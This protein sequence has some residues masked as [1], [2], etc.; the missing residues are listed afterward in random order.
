MPESLRSPRATRPARRYEDTAGVEVDIATSVAFKQVAER[1]AA[2]RFVVLIDCHTFS[3]DRG[4]A[5]RRVAALVGAFVRKLLPSKL[6]F[7]FIFTKTDALLG[8]ADS[9]AVV[10]AKL[11]QVLIETLQGTTDGDQ[12]EFINWLITCIHFDNSLVDVY[13]PAFSK[14]DKL[15]SAIETFEKPSDG[16]KPPATMA[17]RSPRTDVRCGLTPKAES[18]IKLDLD[19]QLDELDVALANGCIASAG[20]IVSTLSFL[21]EQVD[22]PYVHAAHEKALKAWGER[23]ARVALGRTY[24]LIDCGFGR[25]EEHAFDEEQGREALRSLGT[26]RLFERHPAPNVQAGAAEKALVHLRRGLSEERKM[27]EAGLCS[28]DLTAAGVDQGHCLSQEL[29]AFKH[30]M[31]SHSRLAVWARVHAEFEVTAEVSLAKLNTHAR[32][33]IE[34]AYAPPPPPEGTPA[35]VLV[36]MQLN[37]LCHSIDSTRTTEPEALEAA[38]EACKDKLMS[39]L[40]SVVAEAANASGASP[41]GAEGDSNGEGSERISFCLEPYLASLTRVEGFAALL[42]NHSTSGGYPQ[43][44]YTATL[45]ARGTVLGHAKAQMLALREE[46]EQLVGACGASGMFAGASDSSTKMAKRSV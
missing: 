3:V 16:T 10:L 14:V 31:Q 42:A 32:W 24:A 26:L 36:M 17:L 28:I 5:M 2:L 25:S 34:Y 15:R 18:R 21:Q 45:A 8:G 38:L 6:A 43:L 33:L 11:K 44:L 1:C 37:E 41:I 13:H 9:R 35:F 39:L 19:A 30:A 23:G 40:S 22:K 27:V 4:G 20:K 12:K 29:A 46:V 7:S